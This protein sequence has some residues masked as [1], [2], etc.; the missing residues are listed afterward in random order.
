MYFGSLDEAGARQAAHDFATDILAQF[1]VKSLT[2]TK[3]YFESALGGIQEIWSMD[4]DGSN[5]KQLTFHKSITM[6]KA[7]SPDGTM[8][9]YAVQLRAAG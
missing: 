3:I 1:G 7:I 8:M 4:A 2:G 5:Q 6:G 9:A